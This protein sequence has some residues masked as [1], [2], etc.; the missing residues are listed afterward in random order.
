[1]FAKKNLIAL[2]ALATLAV[3]AQAQSSVTLYGVVDVAVGRFGAPFDDSRV[4]PID[5][6]GRCV[7]RAHQQAG[8]QGS[9]FTRPD[10]QHHRQRQ[11][12]AL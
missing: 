3:S 4:G 10:L 11:G 6:G 7:R 2:A 9:L 5:G 1:M 12:H 8:L